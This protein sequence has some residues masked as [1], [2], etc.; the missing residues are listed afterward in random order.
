M[1]YVDPANDGTPAQGQ[2]INANWGKDVQTDIEVLHSGV[3]VTLPQV[4]N[5]V[6]LAPYVFGQIVLSPAGAY[7]PGVISL[8]QAK[9]TFT[10]ASTFTSANWTRLGDIQSGA[11]VAVAAIVPKPTGV[12]ATDTANLT[13]AINQANTST[14]RCVMP[15]AGTYVINATLPTIDPSKMS[16]EGPGAYLC[17]IQPTSAVTGDVLRV[18]ESTFSATVQSARIGGFTVDGTNA[19]TGACGLHYG[20][21]IGGWLD[22]LVAQNFTTAGAK[23]IWID[24]RTNWTERTLWTRVWANNNTTGVLFD[25]NGGKNS[26]LYQ[27]MFDVRINANAGQV[28]IMLQAGGGFQRGIFNVMGN[29]GGAGCTFIEISGSASNISESLIQIAAEMN[30]SG[31]TG[32]LV[33]TGAYISGG[34]GV[35]DLSAGIGTPTNTNNGTI[36]FGGWFNCPGIH[37][38]SEGV[39]ALG[40]LSLVP[41]PND[42][43]GVGLKADTSNN[44][45]LF[46]PSAG[47]SIILRPNGPESGTG[48]AYLD[49]AG[50]LHLSPTTGVGNGASGNLTALAKGTG[51]GPA[52]DVVNGWVP[53]V[54]NGVSGWLP[55][56]V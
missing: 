24:N 39:A 2:P 41:G 26:W 6:A 7:L 28:G 42:P 1:A 51:T 22:D 14:G 8:V 19:G 21:T 23:G 31:S 17:S 43:T 3:N 29:Y 25:V 12:A 4:P 36:Q 15:Y 38:A 37:S 40:G 11:Y 27:R 35:I 34:S 52:S 55:F 54:I 10:E 9:A 30:T 49:T 18:T 20:D 32:L 46:A 13:A 5:W 44:L 16:F 53:V 50:D 56:F 45:F 47:G 33:G 48:Q